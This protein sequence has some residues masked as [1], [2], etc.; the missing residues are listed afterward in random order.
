[1]SKYQLTRRT[2]LKVAGAATVGAAAGAGLAQ[3]LGQQPVAFVR[4]W[5]KWTDR[6]DWEQAPFTLTNIRRPEDTADSWPVDKVVRSGCSFCPVACWHLVQVKGG[7]VVNV[8]GEPKNP[9]QADTENEVDGALCAKGRTGIVQLLYNKYRI[10]RPMKRKGAKPSLDF[11]PISWQ[12]A[13]EEIAKKLLEIRD[14]DGPQAIASKTTDRVSRDGGPPLFRLLHMLGSPNPT[15]EGY[16]CNDAGWM[17]LFWVFGYGRGQTNGWGWD[18]LTQTYDLGDSKFILWV[19]SNDAETHPILHGWMR[20]RKHA[21]KSTWVVVDPRFTATAFEADMWLPVK[22]GTDMALAYGMIHYIINNDL[23]DKDFV[24][25]WVEG[26]DELK[27]FVN[28]KGYSP[29]W[30]APITGIPA[31]TIKKVAKAYATTKPAAIITNAG[32]NH[33]VNAVDTQRV[34]AFLVAITGNLGVP[35]GGI[36]TL[37]NSGAGL[38]LPA[39]E[40]KSD[41]DKKWIEENAFKKPGLPPQPDYFY[42]AVLEGKPY[43]IKAVIYHGNPV[44][45]NSDAKRAREA[46]SKLFVVQVGMFPEE[47]SEYA[48]YILPNTTFYEMDHVHRR[49]DRGLMF[50]N[51]VVDPIGE[52]KQDMLIMAEL[53]QTM[54]KFDTKLSKAYWT[55]NFPTWWATDKKRLWNTIAAGGEQGGMTADRMEAMIDQKGEMGAFA[56]KVAVL[57]APCPAADHAVTKALKPEQRA[58]DG[59]HPGTSVMYADADWWKGLFDGARFPNNK[60]TYGVDKVIIYH[61]KHNETLQKLGHSSI[62]E[63]YMSPENMDGNP[64]LEYLDEFVPM[65]WGWW[66]SAAGNVVHKVKIGVKPDEKLR[67]DYPI[68]LITGRPGVAHFHSITH[69]AWSLVQITGDLYCQ[70]HPKLA[71]K[72]GVKTGDKVKVETPRGSLEVNALV[73]DGIQENTVFIPFTFGSKQKVH[74][75][76][77]RKAWESVNVLTAHYYDNLSGQN[78]YKCQL[79]RVTKA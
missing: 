32:I 20:R 19:G 44:I 56:K 61:P 46:Y 26:F 16:I 42:R 10:T 37:H 8:Y 71:Q 76:V 55:E 23:H 39:I 4:P 14:T 65:A 73:W 59:G 48:D 12:Q 36:V 75:D 53:A 64:T 1:M 41:A 47:I 68:Q 57:R 74:E 51:K 21:I 72:L 43:P 27:K 70:I 67:T 22:P 13:Y 66:N 60:K 17:A 9:I 7:R 28:E 77:G 38:G 69:W 15:H 79:C 63:F 5:N 33:H 6:V 2:F 58:P 50:R 11:E 52:A 31:D 24:A 40:P 3:V 25:K 54:A 18:P 45:V 29:E 35:G 78:E 34:F 62:P 49:L 30:A